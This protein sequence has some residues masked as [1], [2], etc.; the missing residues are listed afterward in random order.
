MVV[1]E[2]LPGDFVT[3]LLLA[4]IPRTTPPEIG[5]KYMLDW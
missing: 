5:K 1:G 2:A 3:C 4:P